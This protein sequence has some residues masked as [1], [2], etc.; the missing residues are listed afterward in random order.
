MSDMPGLDDEV[1]ARV[2]QAAAPMDMLAAA[3]LGL[4]ELSA[5]SAGPDRNSRM[6]FWGDGVAEKALHSRSPGRLG[7]WLR[8]LD[9][10]P[11]ECSFFPPLW[12]TSNR[13]HV[14]GVIQATSGAKAQP[15]HSA[16]MSGVTSVLCTPD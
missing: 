4:H 15:L 9:E 6:S 7:G 3:T 12:P 5:A 11:W 10:E 13:V 16:I 14:D 8:T 1:M 2:P